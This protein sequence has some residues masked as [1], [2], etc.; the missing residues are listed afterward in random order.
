MKVWK[1]VTALCILIAVLSAAGVAGAAYQGLAIR[2]SGPGA[3][4][5][6]CPGGLSRL[7]GDDPAHVVGGGRAVAELAARDSIVPAYKLDLAT[8]DRHHDGRVLDVGD[9]ES[10]ERAY[11]AI[12]PGSLVA[13]ATDPALGTADHLGLAPSAVAW[14]FEERAIAGLATDGPTLDPSATAVDAALIRGGIVVASAG[15][16]DRLNVRGDLVIVSPVDSPGA[17]GVESAPVA[18]LLVCHGAGR[19]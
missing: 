5:V 8:A 7:D 2:G 14:L 10:Y 15:D 19:G 3:A 9:L 12:G 18:G 16:L 11:G 17:S 13:I 6:Q 4:T 1:I